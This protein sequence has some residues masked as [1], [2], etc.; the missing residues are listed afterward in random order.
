[1]N[2][3]EERKNNGQGIFY[4]VIG[5]ATLVVTIIGATFAF[6]TA[7][8]SSNNDAI[9]TGAAVISLD[10][11]ENRDGIKSDLIPMDETNSK[12]ASVV[13]DGDGD[14]KDDNGNNICSVFQFTLTNPRGNTA[15]QTVYPTITSKT[16]EFTNLHYAIFV[17]AVEDIS[18]SASFATTATASPVSSA[19][20]SANGTVATNGTL[21]V[22][23]EVA[24][25]TGA[26]HISTG[27]ATAPNALKLQNMIQTLKPGDS[28][29]YTVVLW[30][31]EI[32]NDTNPANGGDQTAVDS[33]IT[34]G[35][36]TRARIFE[37]GITFST[38]GGSGGVTGKL[39]TT[40]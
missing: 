33:V 23:N 34:E 4:A 37:A 32:S 14:C 21:I 7:T 26:S 20:L 22:K 16:N 39:S 36:S 31:H 1:M 27:T 19:P 30:I 9:S 13:G 15:N 40:P 8:A 18:D 25:A 3:T 11:Q 38:A 12:F 10:L 17:G 28:V 6:F 2:N 24:P 5:V 29:T 35:G